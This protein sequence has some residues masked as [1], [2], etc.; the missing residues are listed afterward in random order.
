MFMPTKLHLNVL[1]TVS[2]LAAPGLAQPE[3]QQQQAPFW[4]DFEFDAFPPGGS[5]GPAP[6][7]VEDDRPN[8]VD[9]ADPPEP[10]GRPASPDPPAA[11]ADEARLQFSFRFQPWSEVLNWF[12]DQAGY[13]L[14][15]DLAPTGT[16]NYTDSREYTAAEAIDLLNSVLVTKGYTLVLRNRMLLLVNL[17]DDIPPSLIAE[18][19]PDELENRGTFELLSTRFQLKNLSVDEAQDEIEELLGPQGSMIALPKARQLVITETGGRLRTICDVLEQAE[20]SR[21]PAEHAMQWFQ[22]HSV[23]PDEVVALLRQMFD[24]PDNGNAIPDGSLQ[25]ATDPAGLRLLAA[26]R[27]ERL[28]QVARM[29]ETIDRP[30]FGQQPGAGPQAAPQIEVYSVA[31]ADPESALK[32]MQTLLAESPGARLALDPR[33]N[34]LVA[35]ARPSEHA[36]IRATLEQ[37]QRDA[38]SVEVIRLRTVDPHLAVL[39]INKLFAE[40]GGKPPS[41]DADPGSRQLLIR[42][43]EGQI[44]Q[45]RSLLEKMGESRHAAGTRSGGK[46]RLVPVEGGDAKEL[47]Q[48]LQQLWPNMHENDLRVVPAPRA[49]SGQWIDERTPVP[50]APAAQPPAV[51][52]PPLE[53]DTPSIQAPATPAAPVQTPRLPSPAEPSPPVRAP[54]VPSPPESSLPGPP[55]LVPA[56]PDGP[57][58]ALPPP[59]FQMPPAGPPSPDPASEAESPAVPSPPAEHLFPPIPPPSGNLSPPD[60]P[61]EPAGGDQRQPE[62]RPRKPAIFAVP[63]SE[64]LYISSDDTEALDHLESLIDA[65]TGGAS[66]QPKLTV[67]YLRHIQAAPAAERLNQLLTNSASGA[68]ETAEGAPQALGIL[69]TLGAA[70]AAGRITLAGPVSIT[71]DARLNALLVQGLPA[72]V[73]TVEQLLTVL[74]RPGSPEEVAAESKPRLIPVI[75]TT[76]AEI[77]EVVKEVYQDRLVVASG[78]MTPQQAM[79]M[80]M[81]RGSRQGGGMPGGTPGGAAAA[82]QMRQ[83]TEPEV[84]L[85]IGVDARTNSVIVAAPEPLFEEVRSLVLALDQAA[86]EENQTV[87]VMT[88]RNSNPETVRAALGTILGDSVQYGSGSGTQRSG[89]GTTR[90]WTGGTGTRTGTRQYPGGTYRRSSGQRSS[91]R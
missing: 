37:M 3:M 71:P 5:A 61:V 35:L 81:L 18:V 19:S 33:T 67:F 72:D 10:S 62:G 64:G 49:A 27:P 74:D 47:L 79:V 14:V 68:P 44:V 54:L 84:K 30:A 9:P 4:A 83:S 82:M 16:F 76:A 23:A 36:T 88:L 46:L 91:G 73:K 52:L 2:L 29:L 65:L 63:S 66:G 38:G 34:N 8:Q 11:P 32:V 1:L 50:P 53:R 51:R 48:R 78:R 77:A 12:A 6:S 21:D 90:T 45:I 43:S 13:S 20:R 85:S 75:H 87:Q 41:V 69:G 86:S 40:E 39:A 80:Q 24:I 31:P 17:E 55:E 28:A 22:L 58:P 56:E 26:G 42:G 60:E 7:A 89:T 59:V 25:F 15:L 70:G 57:L